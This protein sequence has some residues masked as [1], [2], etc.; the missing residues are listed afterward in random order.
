MAYINVATSGQF[1]TLDI[2]GSADFTS[3]VANAFVAGQAANVVTVPG[4]QDI[5]V[6]ATPGLFRWKQLDSLSEYVVT[7]PSTNSLSMTIVLDPTTFFTGEGNTAGLFSLVNNKT[8]TSFRLYWQGTTTGDR[9]IEGVGYL[10]G[11]AATVNPDSPVW[12]SP[13]TIEVVGD[14]STGTVA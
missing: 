13:I 4:L 14:Y 1:A 5:T 2:N 6:N 9:Y 7:T 11:L 10:S 3:N 8:L 12:T